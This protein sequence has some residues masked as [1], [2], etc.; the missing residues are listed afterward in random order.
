MVGLARTSVQVIDNVLAVVAFFQPKPI[1]P[2]STVVTRHKVGDV[3]AWKKGHEDRVRIFAPAMT[4]YQAFQDLDDPNSVVLVMET[5]DF[6]LLGAMINDP[7]HDGIKASHT[8]L[9]PITISMP[10]TFLPLLAMSV[11]A[12][13]PGGTNP[14]SW[15]SLNFSKPMDR[16]TIGLLNLFGN[17]PA[18]Q[19]QSHAGPTKAVIKEINPN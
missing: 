10:I 5:T 6:E 14:I 8:V 11:G 18:T 2:M 16:N 3:E 13:F 7:Q 15:Q 4:S 1:N 19:A 12:S 9:E 17:K